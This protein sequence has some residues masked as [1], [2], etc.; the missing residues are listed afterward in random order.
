MAAAWRMT[1]SPPLCW[2]Q[3]T[4]PTTDFGEINPAPPAPLAWTAA[5]VCVND[6]PTV[7]YQATG[8]TG[9]TVALFWITEGWP[10]GRA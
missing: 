8:A 7:Q 6:A 5:A 1:G 4:G 10:P 2:S 3:A 9:G